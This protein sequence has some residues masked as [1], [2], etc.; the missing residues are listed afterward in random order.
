VFTAV[1][2]EVAVVDAA[3]FAHVVTVVAAVVGRLHGGI[4]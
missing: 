4:V 1:A 3:G 2:A